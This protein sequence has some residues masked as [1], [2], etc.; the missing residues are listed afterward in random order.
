MKLHLERFRQFEE[1]AETS[2]EHLP[3]RVECLF[4][5][6]YHLIDACAAKHRIHID[7]HQR[8]RRELEA[9][10]EIFGDRTPEVWQAFQALERR[11]RPKFVYGARGTEEDMEEVEEHYAIIRAACME[12]LGERAGD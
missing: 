6:A 3:V 8:V 12:V 11:L 7:K 9:N 2:K 5:A 1:G 10:V 4:I